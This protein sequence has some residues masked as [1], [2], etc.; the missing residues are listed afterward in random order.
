MYSQVLVKGYQEPEPGS[1]CSPY[2]FGGQ[3]GIQRF[4]LV[5]ALICVPWMLCAKP[6]LL[7][8]TNKQKQL[9]SENFVSTS[10]LASRGNVKDC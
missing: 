3:F 4:L 9:V 1:P 10:A 6:F 5:V 2:M 7:Y 8:R